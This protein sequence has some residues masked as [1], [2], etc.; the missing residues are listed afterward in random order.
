MI[1]RLTLDTDV[2]QEFW[3]EQEKSAQTAALLRLAEEGHVD[4]AVTRRIRA[5]IPH[6]ALA[7]KIDELPLLRVRETGVAFRI[8]ESTLGGPD[9][10][11][12]EAFDQFVRFEVP[13]I[14]ERLLAEG[15]LAKRRVPD[16]RDWQHIEAHFIQGRDVFLTFDRGIQ[17]W[18]TQL[19][20]R[21]GIVVMAPAENL[22]T[23]GVP[24]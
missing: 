5:D 18:S 21:F 9:G 12:S 22:S 13:L 23:H 3:R 19:R 4:L 2:L 14:T 7:S 8:G 17:A 20:E 6:E 10:L 1:E 15:R 11:G 24:F 16:W